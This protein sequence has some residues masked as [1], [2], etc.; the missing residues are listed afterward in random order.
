MLIVL[1]LNSVVLV[2]LWV[3]GLIALKAGLISTSISIAFVLSLQ[4][5][6]SFMFI[7]LIKN[8]QQDSKG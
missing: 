3:M 8:R 7:N 2:G 4:L 5:A 6:L 1:I